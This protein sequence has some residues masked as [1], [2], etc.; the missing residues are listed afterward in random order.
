MPWVDLLIL[1]GIQTQ[2][3]F[4]LARLY[5]QPLTRQRYLEFASTLGMGMLVRQGVRELMKFIP[6]VG[7]IAA[8]ALAGSATFALG[9]AFCFFYG[10]VLKG[11][12]PRAE[13]L[14]RYYH[15]QLQ[16]AERLWAKPADK[17]E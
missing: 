1:P 13:D 3:I 7:S 9:K 12:V 10:N 11:H 4:H 14:K 2:M 17:K 15:E 16:L 5:D 8:A 6:G